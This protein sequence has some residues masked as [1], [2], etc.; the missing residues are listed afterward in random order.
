V[1]L[2]FPLAPDSGTLR[3]SQKRVFVGGD[4]PP[5]AARVTQRQSMIMRRI[6][7]IRR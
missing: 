1:F 4:L 6:V 7:A 3:F 2:R 5:P